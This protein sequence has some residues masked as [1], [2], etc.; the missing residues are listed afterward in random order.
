MSSLDLY[1]RSRLALLAGLKLQGFKLPPKGCVVGPLVRALQGTAGHN[2]IKRWFAV[3]AEWPEWVRA[4]ERAA[5]WD[6][7]AHEE[8]GDKWVGRVKHVERLVT[9]VVG[10]RLA[11]TEAHLAATE[12]ALLLVLGRIE[13]QHAQQAPAAR[14]AEGVD[15]ATHSAKPAPAGC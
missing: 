11:K 10:A 4:D 1:L 2:R 7:T 5:Q 3:H 13:A 9:H 12:R 15:Q 8:A 6:R 14:G